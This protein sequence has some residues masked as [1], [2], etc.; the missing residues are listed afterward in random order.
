[1][2]TNKTGVGYVNSENLAGSQLWTELDNLNQQLNQ[3]LTD[4]DSSIGTAGTSGGTSYTPADATDWV[5]P[6]PTT[7]AQ[8]L[9][10]I[11]DAVRILRG[12]AIP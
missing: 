11:A 4:L 2:S 9:D 1:M 6:V 10:R 7:V 8:A 3:R 12:S 5:S